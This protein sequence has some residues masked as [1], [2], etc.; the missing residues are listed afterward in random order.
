M[1]I[2]P[3]PCSALCTKRVDHTPLV[4]IITGGFIADGP[5]VLETGEVD[6][7]VA[8]LTCMALL[9]QRDAFCMPGLDLGSKK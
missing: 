4:Q 3:P 2:I 7:L 5:L 6:K 9:N 8:L 1:G